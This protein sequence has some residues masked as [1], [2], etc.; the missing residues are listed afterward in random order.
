[1][2]MQQAGPLDISEEAIDEV[3]TIIRKVHLETALPDEI[4]RGINVRTINC[5]IPGAHGRVPCRIYTPE[6]ARRLLTILVFF[7]GGGWISGDLDT[8]EGMA[9][10]L[11]AESGA[12]VINVGYRLAPEFRFPVAVDDCYAALCWAEEHAAELGGDPGRLCVVGDSAGG[13]LAAVV[14]H[15]SKRRG[16]PGVARQVL[17]YPVVEAPGT[18][19]RSRRLFGNGAY[20]LSNTELDNMVRLYAGKREDLDDFRFSPLLA[21]DFSGLPKTLLV[22]AE[23]DLLC[24]EGRVYAEKL[25]NAG[26]VVDYRLYRGTVHGFVTFAGAISLGMDALDYV[27]RYLRQVRG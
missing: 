8:H 27:A 9:Q 18:D 26:V 10:Y 13:N 22:A 24:D 17:I 1:M 15:L 11:C 21:D 14:C 5:D 2:K 3:R 25:T 16:G 23:C 20:V 7:H 12:I 6:N 4:S 19:N